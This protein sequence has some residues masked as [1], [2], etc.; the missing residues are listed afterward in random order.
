MSRQDLPPAVPN[1]STV[2]MFDLSFAPT[3][4]TR[5]QE[6]G[7][8]ADVRRWSLRALALLSVLNVL[9][10][11]LTKAFLRAG[12]QEGN[13]VMAGL[14]QDWRMGALKVIVLGALFLKTLTSPPSVTRACLLWGAVGVY[15]VASWVNWQVLQQ[16]P[17]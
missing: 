11:V 5:I 7:I 8:A 4:T 2:T 12:L 16:L 10:V 1:H 17:V 9:D 15:A 14:V 3:S 6:E 13:P